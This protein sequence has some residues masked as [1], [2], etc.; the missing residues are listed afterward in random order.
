MGKV[1]FEDPVD[2]ISGKIS[3]KKQTV[4]N[5]RRASD[6]RYTQVRGERNGD[7]TPIE[8]AQRERFRIVREAAQE[9]MMDVEKVTVDR[10]EWRAALKKGDK[11]TTLFGFVFAKCYKYYDKDTKTVVCPN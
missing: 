8:L 1:V 3:K 5:R 4:F 11:H 7:P 6:K 9:R 2:Y 10:A